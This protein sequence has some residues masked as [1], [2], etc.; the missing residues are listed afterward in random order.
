MTRWLSVLLALI[1]CPL[2]SNAPNAALDPSWGFALHAWASSDIPVTYFTYG[3]LGFLT[4]PVL[5][6]RWTYLLA[7]LFVLGIHVALCR[8]LLVRL[9]R[10]APLPVAV[11]VTFLVAALTDA[12]I[13]EAFTVVLALLAAEV[14]QK[15]VGR[16]RLWFAGGVAL[17]GLALLVKFSTGVT[18]LALLVVVAFALANGVR[19][20]FVTAAAAAG[21]SIA[22]SWL[23]FGV[24]TGDFGAFP[25]WLT[26]SREIARG[27]PAMAVELLE[28]TAVHYLLGLAVAGGLVATALVLA[29]RTRD[30]ARLAVGAVLLLLGYLFFRE[31][32]T[33]HDD[34]HEAS[35]IAAMTVLPFALILGRRSRW[36]LVPL[37]VAPMGFSLWLS[38]G[39]I[40]EERYNI[41]NTAATVVGHLG[42]A[43]DPAPV[44]KQAA[45]DIRSAFPIPADALAALRDRRV[46]VDPFNTGVLW[47][48]DLE[49]GPSKVW[50]LYTSYTPWL[51]NRNAASIRSSSG[52]ESIL[53]YGEA[54]GI[55]SRVARFESPA[56]QLTEQCAWRSAVVSGSWQVLEP[57]TN[58]CSPGRRIGAVRFVP[59]QRFGVPL[60]SR[61]DSIVTVRFELDVAVSTQ[62]WSLAFKPR[63]ER[64][65][66][67]DGRRHRLVVANAGQPLVLRVPAGVSG[68]P[69][70]F[71]AVNPQVLQLDLPGTAVFEEVELMS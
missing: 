53:R 28:P 7:L 52:P 55:D 62:L 31:G 35:F 16:P 61:P 68:D 21:C 58:R 54:G 57:S 56:Y 44:Q 18:A 23:A 37:V 6:N 65:L 59:G 26:A 25:G 46:Q 66:T 47:A 45:Q 2:P 70:T 8:L 49:W 69:G 29:A 14:L 36:A 27:Y 13:A 48:Y 38:D 3:P 15:G 42:D 10:I 33:R 63:T 9:L 51:D 4:V 41:G 64:Y 71:A 30:T 32:Y 20:R 34:L 19:A 22:L 17:S 11:V 39:R 5:W 24:L 1:T 12:F 67:M 50:A 60:A 43:I 40:V